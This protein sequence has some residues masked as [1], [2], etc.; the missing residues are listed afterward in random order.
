MNDTATMECE[1]CVVERDKKLSWERLSQCT[2]KRN[3]YDPARTL[4]E[5]GIECDA[6][7]LG[8]AAGYVLDDFP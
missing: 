7:H 2:D 3:Q 4:A 6:P 5:Q 1:V 8:T